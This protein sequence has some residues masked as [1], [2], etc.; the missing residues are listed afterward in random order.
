MAVF[1]KE[2]TLH[3]IVSEIGEIVTWRTVTKK[4]KQWSVDDDRAIELAY[5]VGETLASCIVDKC[6]RMKIGKT[7]KDM[8]TQFANHPLKKL[9]DLKSPMIR[10]LLVRLLTSPAIVT[11]M[12]LRKL[13]REREKKTVSTKTRQRMETGT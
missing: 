11:G 12:E 5:G 7:V 8:K 3:T 10:P 2:I 13:L 6:R 1:L 9:R 4:M